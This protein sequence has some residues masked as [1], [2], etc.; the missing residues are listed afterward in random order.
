MTV[1]IETNSP[2]KGACNSKEDG[3][4]SKI[5]KIYQ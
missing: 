2:E 4:T 3:D 1:I 5:G